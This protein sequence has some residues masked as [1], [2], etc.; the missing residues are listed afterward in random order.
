[1]IPAPKSHSAVRI[2]AATEA[3]TARIIRLVNAA[4]AIET[5]LDGTRTDEQRMA[6]KMRTGKFLL[7]QDESGRPLACVYIEHRGERGYFGMLAVDPSQQGKGLGRLMVEAAEGRCRDRG[8]KFM[9]IT[10]LSLRTELP[11]FYRKLGYVETGTKPFQPAHPLRAG[12]ECHWILMSKS[13]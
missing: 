7:A 10:V 13:L 1:M 11:P 9:D 6:E 8:C 5:F 12:V 2:E 3:D 4:F